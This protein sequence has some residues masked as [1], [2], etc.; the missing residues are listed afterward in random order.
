MM[1]FK[2]PVIISIVGLLAFAACKKGD[3]TAI[4]TLSTSVNLINATGDTINFYINGNRLNTAASLYPLSATGYLSTPFGNQNY[5]VKKNKS[6]VVLYS[7]ALPLDTGKVYSFYTTGNTAESAFSTVDTLKS[8]QS[9]FALVRFV[10]TSPNAGSL[11][12]TVNDSLKYEA[13]AYG[14]SSN[15]QKIGPGLKRLVVKKAGTTD[16]LSI[17]TR[18]LLQG[19]AYTIFTKSSLT[20]TRSTTPATGIIINR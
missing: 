12:F 14:T 20:S 9:K 4:T 10:N 7:I 13:R 15:Y 2:I 16:T 6:A 5:Q 8:V 18:I 1:K 19:R 17:D 3:D 11:D